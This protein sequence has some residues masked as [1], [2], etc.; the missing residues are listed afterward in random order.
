[1]AL[2]RSLADWALGVAPYPKRNPQ[3]PDL[4]TDSR[5]LAAKQ[6]AGCDFAVK[7]DIFRAQD[8]FRLLDRAAANGA[9]LHIIPAIMPVTNLS[10]IQRFARLSGAEF[11]AELAERFERVGDDPDA[12]RALGVEVATDLCEEVLR[13]GAPGLHFYTLNRST[14]TR[15]IY[16]RL[17]LGVAG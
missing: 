7:Q 14:A 5:L 1:M 15:E 6:A 13:G 9:S 10:Q 8:Y 16:G 4:D 17:G 11:P 2:L 3:T 12:V